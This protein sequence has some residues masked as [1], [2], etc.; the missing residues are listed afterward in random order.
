MELQPYDSLGPPPPP[1]YIEPS[2]IQ[3]TY[4]SRYFPGHAAG[5]HW[6]RLRELYADFP[7][8]IYRHYFKPDP[9]DRKFANGQLVWCWVITKDGKIVSIRDAARMPGEHGFSWWA[10]SSEQRTQFEKGGVVYDPLL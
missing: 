7:V 1:G 3:G 10:F 9:D 2:G 8:Q 5:P 4:K 6:I